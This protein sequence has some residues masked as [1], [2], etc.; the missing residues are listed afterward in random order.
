VIV[1]EGKQARLHESS[2]PF[3]RDK[4]AH[5][6]ENGADNEFGICSAKGCELQSF[7]YIMHDASWH[8]LTALF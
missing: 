2:Q 1:L 3:S 6:H 7:I 8:M 4:E 5:Y